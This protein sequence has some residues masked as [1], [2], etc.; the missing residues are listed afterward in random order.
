MQPIIVPF[1]PA[2]YK[3]VCG[4]ALLIFAALALLWGAK[5]LLLCIR[6]MR[7]KLP[8]PAGSSLRF[9]GLGVVLYLIF[10]AAGAAA[11]VFF[12]A[13]VTTGPTIVSQDGILVAA[14]LPQF[15]SQ[16][17]PWNEITKVTCNLPPRED[18]I[19]ILRFYS[20]GPTVELGDAGLPL[21]GVLAV[22]TE[23]APRG[24]VQPCKHG[25]LD[26]STSY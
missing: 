16:F 25:H 24:T 22:A 15:Q 7:G 1:A 18:R 23:R 19:R 10:V 3:I 2:S 26:H 21:N 4:L 14:R 9:A 17:I 12:L 11:M 20:Q 6:I 8:L 13:L 5:N